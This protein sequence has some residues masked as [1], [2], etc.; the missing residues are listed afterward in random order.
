VASIFVIL[1]S[2]L[3]SMAECLRDGVAE[4]IACG[5]SGIRRA[6]G[7][8][9]RMSLPAALL[10][11]VER[12]PCFTGCYR[13]DSEVQACVDAAQ[14]LAPVVSVACSDCLTFHPGALASLLPLGMTSY[15]LANALSAHVRALR[16][17]RWATGGYH[18]AGGG[19]W[20]SAAYYG[21][22]LFLVD[23]ARNRSSR[24]DA[25][26]LAEAFRHSVLQPEDPRMVDPGLYTSELAYISMATPI[27]PVQSKQ[28]LLASPQRSATPKQ[29]FHRV[30]IVEF[31]P[32]VAAAAA[33][34]PAQ[35]PEEA[36]AP[37]E[38]QLGEACPKC[39]AVVM[40]RPLFSGT[41]VGCLC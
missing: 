34:A 5:A 18:T 12:H 3:S 36:Q 39:G 7:Y 16:G 40:E 14:P 13:S 32:L 38:L 33:A 28:D 21:D 31:Q 17:Y 30:S 1:V 24:T 27:L 26:M 10:A 25:E 8:S 29:G 41:F 23:A 37:R 11:A 15:A 35:A 20:L 6:G 22:G 9:S 19:F 2:W 4:S